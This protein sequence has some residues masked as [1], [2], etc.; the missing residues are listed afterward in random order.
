MSAP[1]N[2]PDRDKKGCFV[3]GNSGNP[4]GRPRK[5]GASRPL[6]VLQILTEPVSIRINGDTQKVSLAEARLRQLIT[7]A[8]KGDVKAAIKCIRLAE[9]YKLITPA[10]KHETYPG[11]ANLTIPREW[12]ADEFLEMYQKFGD[13]PWPGERDGLIPPERRTK[14]NPNGLTV[15]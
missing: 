13:P 11:G 9:K 8:M 5:G 14:F 2:K 4:N 6:D 10:I 7:K 12:T 1:A 15:T 3:R